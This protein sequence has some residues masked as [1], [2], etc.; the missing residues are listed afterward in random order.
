MSDSPGDGG[1]TSAAEFE[2]ALREV[3]LAAERNG[4]DPR[5]SWVYD[6]SERG[7]DYEVE[8]YELK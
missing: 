6:G 5:G 3:L 8:V 2:A 1:I 7:T 4:I